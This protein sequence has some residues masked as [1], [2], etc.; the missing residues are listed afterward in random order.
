MI[1]IL[2]LLGLAL[3]G[4]SPV[5]A[6]L[7]RP[8]A[9][10]LPPAARHPAPPAA[11]ASTEVTETRTDRTGTASRKARKTPRPPPIKVEERGTV[12]GPS[13]AG[14]HTT[15]D[16][17]SFPQPA[18]NPVVIEAA[19]T[20]E[21]PVGIELHTEQPVHQQR[22]PLAA[23]GGGQQSVKQ[24][25]A[26]TDGAVRPRRQR[27]PNAPKRVSSVPPAEIIDLSSTSSEDEQA[28]PAQ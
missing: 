13:L 20:A 14:S 25:A 4:R 15:S 5:R 19:E 16:G 2:T 24:E 22:E 9:P 3:A 6:Q 28:P 1:S 10:D 7:S 21:E 17:E 18:G 26:G 11:S 12:I 23:I 8:M 27:D